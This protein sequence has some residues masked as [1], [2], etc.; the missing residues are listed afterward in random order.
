[1]GSEIETSSVFWCR[2][3]DPYFARMPAD[4]VL[5]EWCVAGGGPPAWRLLFGVV[6]FAPFLHESRNEKLSNEQ[7]IQYCRFFFG[8]I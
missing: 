8:L 7:W 4:A 2:C 6:R 1:M 3:V 5:W